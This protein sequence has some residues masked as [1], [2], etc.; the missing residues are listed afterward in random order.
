[1][2]FDQPTK[3]TT[4]KLVCFGASQP[5]RLQNLRAR[6]GSN[7]RPLALQ[8]DRICGRVNRGQVALQLADAWRRSNRGPP[9]SN[10][11]LLDFD[12]NS[13][14]LETEGPLTG[15]VWGKAPHQKTQKKRKEKYAKRM[16]GLCIYP[17]CCCSGRKYT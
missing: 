6:W 4:N 14:N 13:W 11:L 10:E 2:H 8:L 7:W 15:K 5:K 12:V 17:T 16:V 9:S 1:M 3:E